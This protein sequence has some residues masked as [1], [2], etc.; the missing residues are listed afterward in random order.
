[1]EIDRYLKQIR[2]VDDLSYSQAK[3]ENSEQ[4]SSKTEDG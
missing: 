1:M 4:P 3:S 2:E